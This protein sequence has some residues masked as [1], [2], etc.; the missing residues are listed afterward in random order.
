MRSCKQ[1]LLPEH[2]RERKVHHQNYLI[3]LVGYWCITNTSQPASSPSP[4]KYHS[5]SKGNTMRNVH[6]EYHG[7]ALN[8]HSASLL[9]KNAAREDHMKEPTIMAWHQHSGV[10]P[11]F[12][13]GANPDTWWEKYGA[14]NGGRLEISVGDDFQFVMM[15]ARGYETLG[16][17]PLRNLSDSHGN[18]YLCH[19]TS[20]A[21][22]PD[23]PTLEA[24]SLLDGW[25][26]DQ[27]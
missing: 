24:C 3:C 7:T 6:I 23:T 25:A 13:E 1:P 16:K 14:G 27:F 11:A 4:A 22:D 12:Y 15:D 9:A 17:A 26:A 18:Q 19:T 2:G 5:L 8:Y 10:M 21:K 20:L